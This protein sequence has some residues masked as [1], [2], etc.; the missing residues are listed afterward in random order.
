MHREFSRDTMTAA[1]CGAIPAEQ[2]SKSLQLITAAA[3]LRTSNVS[4][5][6][7][8]NEITG[9]RA[10]SSDLGLQTIALCGRECVRKFPTTFVAEILFVSG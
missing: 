3:N 9:R 4:E 8:S 7:M 1:V 6:R 5:R 2:R 10:F